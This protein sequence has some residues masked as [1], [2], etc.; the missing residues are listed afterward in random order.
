M[1][2]EADAWINELAS[3]NMP[4]YNA[5]LGMS[6]FAGMS[7]LNSYR[8]RAPSVM[9]TLPTTKVDYNSARI[10]ALSR[11]VNRYKPAIE[12]TYKSFTVTHSNGAGESNTAITT[13]FGSDTDFQSKM[14]GDRVRLK[15][16]TLRWHLEA[17]GLNVMRFILYSP[18]N[19]GERIS[20]FNF[21]SIVDQSKFRVMKDLTIWPSASLNTGPRPNIG[22]FTV[23][24]R[25]K[26]ARYD[27]TSPTAMTIQSGEIVLY[28]LTSTT[29]GGITSSFQHRLNYQNK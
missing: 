3:Y 28:I 4:G 29:T 25:N 27:R 10:Q 6:A 26:M 8:N 11:A 17:S 23:S 7:A 16:Y 24:L 12:N 15:T 19:T 21:Q 9:R 2:S 18:L 5:A 20:S 14:L 13:D 1:P 22:Q